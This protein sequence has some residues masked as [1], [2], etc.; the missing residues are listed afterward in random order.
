M[1]ASDVL[2]PDNPMPDLL[3]RIGFRRRQGGYGSATQLLWN[4]LEGNASLHALCQAREDLT[5]ED[6]V[7]LK[8]CEERL[9]VARRC[10]DK[11]T[12]RWSFSFWEVIHEVDGLLLLVLP[13]HMLLPKALEIQQQFERRVTDAAQGRLWLGANRMEGPLPQCV[14]MLS[15]DRPVGASA[16]LPPLFP[17][18]LAYCRHVLR[19]ALGVINEQ[20]DKTFW[21]LSINVSIQIL[22]T[23]L[24]LALFFVAFQ[25]FSPSLVHEWP[26]GVVPMGMLVLSLAGAAGAILSNMLSKQRF[27]VATGAT[28]RYFAYH[29]LVKPVIGGFAALMLLF[30]EQSQLLLSVVIRPEEET[31]TQA[32]APAPP[33]PD[34][35]NRPPEPPGD[36][37]NPAVLHI[38]V[39]SREAAFFTM[40]ALAVVAGYSADRLLSS[41]M[42]SVLGRL[43][44]QSE[45]LLPPSAP[46]GTPS[47]REQA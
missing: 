24:L 42:D 7:V 1:A 23:T 2:P 28:S 41:V 30:L 44:R 33:A 22:S 45:K 17:G 43:L 31:P 32:E 3:R 37:N 39:S 36:D 13:R 10:L 20:V 4:K 12:R 18:Q 16:A 15:M 34:E 11:P 38:H 47:S 29:L 6:R 5:D 8:Q 35:D 46:P 40:A 9:E 19:G 25:G 14:L 27:V 26:A 21:Q